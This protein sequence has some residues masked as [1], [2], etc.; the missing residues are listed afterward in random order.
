[1]NHIL[2]LLS[3]YTTFFMFLIFFIA[4]IQNKNKKDIYYSL[5]FL[6][7]F[8]IIFGEYILEL[9]PAKDSC[10]LWWHKFQHIGGILLIITFP[11][12][13][14]SFLD[15][16][17]KKIELYILSGIIILLLT[18]LFS[19]ELIITKEIEIWAGV[20]KQGKEGILYPLFFLSLTYVLIENMYILIKEYKKHFQE[21]RK[22]ILLLIIGSFIAIGGGYY[23]LI[24]MINPSFLIDKVPSLFTVGLFILDLI[25]GYIFLTEYSFTLKKLK[26]NEKKVKNMLIKSRIEILELLE[27]ATS[28][29]EAKDKYTAGHSKRVM[30]Y[31]LMIADILNLSDEDKNT[32]KTA[33]ILHDIGKI[34]IPEYILNK[35]GK[36]TTKEY[37]IIKKHPVIGVEILSH[38]HYFVRVLPYIYYHHER[39]DGKGYPEGLK[40]KEIPFFSRIIAVADTFDAI[41]S[42]RPYRKALS[43]KK[44]I[45]ILEEVK[46]TQLDADIVEKF[47]NYLN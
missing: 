33:C 1:M 6:S 5:F 32:L 8:F 20:I 36:L 42:D 37:N 4:G 25:I 7:S 38:F 19:T 10:I 2:T 35:P 17:I 28:T 31:A 12:T 18:L 30:K 40:G 27:L 43:K 11:L 3:A 47:I 34:G 21:K 13:V 44:A 41:T 29:L 14:H 24:G 23:D 9:N 46:D 16:K 39:I 22:N 45:N 15:K 26:I